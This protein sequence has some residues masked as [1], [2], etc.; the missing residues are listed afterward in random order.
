[1]GMKPGKACR[2]AGCPVIVREGGYCLQHQKQQDVRY[3]QTWLRKEA[4]EFYNSTAWKALR[5]KKLSIDPFCERCCIRGISRFAID[6][7]HILKRTDYPARALDITNL[8]SLCK[9]CHTEI[10]KGKQ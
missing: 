3:R 6:V 5:L 2:H 1:M 4:S 10:E 7:H 8:M 9:E